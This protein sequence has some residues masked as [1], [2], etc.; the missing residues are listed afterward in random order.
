MTKSQEFGAL[1]YN[2]FYEY[3]GKLQEKGA[4]IKA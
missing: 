3:F 2:F 1:S 4:Q